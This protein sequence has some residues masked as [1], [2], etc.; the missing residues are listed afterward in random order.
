MP[1][2]G[3]AYDENRG[4]HP[5]MYDLLYFSF[6]THQIRDPTLLLEVDILQV[7]PYRPCLSSA[8]CS[9]STT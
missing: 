7:Q 1:E 3:D 8:S 9:P 5:T 6:M 2:I 4:V